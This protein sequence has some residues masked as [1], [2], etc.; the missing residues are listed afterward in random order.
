MLSPCV[1]QRQYAERKVVVC[2]FHN[3]AHITHSV[4]WRLQKTYNFSQ[5]MNPTTNQWLA[6]NLLVRSGQA[7]P[8]PPGGNLSRSMKH[9][10]PSTSFSSVFM[11]LWKLRIRRLCKWNL[12]AG[13]NP[14]QMHC[15]AGGHENMILRMEPLESRTRKEF[16]MN[17]HAANWKPWKETLATRHFIKIFHSKS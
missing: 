12:S 9:F 16:L 5:V 13:R 15:M 1:L 4:V 7:T 8:I 14:M 17:W 3:T 11:I 6:E 2:P 10:T